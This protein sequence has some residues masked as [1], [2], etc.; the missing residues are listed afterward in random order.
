M[1]FFNRIELLE[2]APSLLT[3]GQASQKSFRKILLRQDLWVFADQN[4]F[5]WSRS[6]GWK[7]GR[8]E[9][10]AKYVVELFCGTI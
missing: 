1:P 3:K 8:C 4:D 5:G 2:A 9:E 7:I 10:I 6:G